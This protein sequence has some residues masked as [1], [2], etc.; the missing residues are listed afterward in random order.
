MPSRVA[1]SPYCCAPDVVTDCRLTVPPVSVVR[2]ASDRTPPTTALKSVVADEFAVR[3]KAP[4]T[5]SSNVMV[6]L[7]VETV[8]APA[9]VVVPDTTKVLLVVV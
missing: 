1:L 7:P 5:V 6:P 4:L 2:L 9:S 8:V 3:A